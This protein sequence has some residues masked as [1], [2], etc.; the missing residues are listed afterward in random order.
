MTRDEWAKEPPSTAAVERMTA[1]LRSHTMEVFMKPRSLLL[2]FAAPA[3]LAGLLSGCSS[4]RHHGDG[5]PGPTRDGAP[6]RG[7]EASAGE[8]G[9]AGSGTGYGQGRMGPGA[10]RLGMGSMMGDRNAM[11]ELNRRLMAARTA[12]ERQ[13]MMNRYM[14]GMSPETREQRLRMMREQCR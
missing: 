2:A 3:L 1:F 12:E 13:A 10:G 14:A 4:W 8:S 7:P 9:T 5:G 6:M 11:C